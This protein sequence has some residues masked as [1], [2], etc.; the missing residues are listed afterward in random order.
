MLNAFNGIFAVF[1]AFIGLTY[2][3]ISGSRNDIGCPFDTVD[4]PVVVWG[5]SQIVYTFEEYV[6]DSTE[7]KSHYSSTSI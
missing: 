5:N 3:I 1:C 6:R 7:Y 2:A 4:G